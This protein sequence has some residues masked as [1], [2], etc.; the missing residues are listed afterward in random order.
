ML[1]ERCECLFRFNR[2]HLLSTK[3][4]GL[5]S[6][7]SPVFLSV[8]SQ[9]YQPPQ[10]DWH[11]FWALHRPNTQGVELPEAISRLFSG[12][13]AVLIFL[14]PQVQRQEPRL[15]FPALRL[16]LLFPPWAQRNQ[17]RDCFPGSAAEPVLTKHPSLICF[18]NHHL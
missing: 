14:F 18:P 15:I 16:V 8:A 7:S 9:C 5:T 12:R 10:G 17:T 3:L 1:F 4:L 2:E 11:H 6:V 13:V